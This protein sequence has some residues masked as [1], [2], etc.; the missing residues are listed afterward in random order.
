MARILPRNKTVRT[1]AQVKNKGIIGFL[2]FAIFV[3]L[4]VL[5]LRTKSPEIPL[6]F[7]SVSFSPDGKTIATAGGQGNPE[8]LPRIGELILWD[9]QSGVRKRI[10]H[11]TS[12]V[13]SVTWAN[14]GK[15]IVMGDFGGGTTLVNPYNCLPFASLPPHGGGKEG[16]VNSVSISS[17][18]L[19]VASG[20][21]DGTITLWDIAGK[22]LEPLS[23]PLGEK[24]FSVAISPNHTLVLAGGGHGKAFLYNLD[25]RGG[26]RVVQAC[27]DPALSESRVETVAF[28]PNGDKIATGCML[29]IRLWDTIS[30]KLIQ[31]VIGSA[32]PINCLAFSPDGKVIA[33]VDAEG[34]LSLWNSSNGELLKS[35]P[36]HQGGSFGVAFSPDGKR[37][38]T[39]GR[40]DFT[41]KIWDVEGL[42]VLR[43]FKRAKTKH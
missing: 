4:S 3:V 24:A 11:H 14:N 8:V 37:L 17:D 40:H 7:W 36:A 42:T 27:E 1:A 39:V 2:L 31:D 32:N 38:A 41:G 30:G 12:S 25:Q 43:T 20:S 22:E 28:T 23:L 29:T 6:Q 16:C 15:F 10:F 34:T 5:Y 13:R 26:P 18:G 33:T 21:V 19:I 35:N 9:S